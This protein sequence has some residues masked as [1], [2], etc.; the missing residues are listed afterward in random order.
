MKKWSCIDT[1]N[2]QYCKE[3]GNGK[4]DFIEI[5]GCYTVGIL[6]EYPDR[7]YT[8]KSSYIDLDDYDQKEREIAICGYY[9]SLDAV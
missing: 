9:D 2:F 8:V 7:K 3:H 6:P 5:V 4:Y 1:D